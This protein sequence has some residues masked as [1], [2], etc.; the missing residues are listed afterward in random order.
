MVKYSAT[1][2][3]SWNSSLDPLSLCLSTAGQGDSPQLQQHEQMHRAHHH[4]SNPMVWRIP[5][6][7]EEINT[8][9]SRF[10]YKLKASQC[11]HCKCRCEGG[12]SPIFGPDE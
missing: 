4:L 6:G 10:D 7:S 11:V 9:F 3:V 8:Q 5:S 2:S 1:V 12:Q